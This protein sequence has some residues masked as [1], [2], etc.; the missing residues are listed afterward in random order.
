MAK[1]IVTGGIGIAEALANRKSALLANPKSVSAKAGARYEH[2]C[3]I[4]DD[5]TLWVAIRPTVAEWKTGESFSNKGETYATLRVLHQASNGKKY[6]TLKD[7][8]GVQIKVEMKADESD[9]SGFA[10]SAQSLKIELPI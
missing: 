7:I 5:G 2:D 10:Q 1:K 9:Y 3:Q 6:G 8:P 4:D